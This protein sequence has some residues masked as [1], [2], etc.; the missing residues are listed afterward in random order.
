MTLFSEKYPKSARA[1]DVSLSAYTAWELEC[2]FHNW[3]TPDVRLYGMADALLLWAASWYNPSDLFANARF[4]PVFYK[5]RQEYA[6][7]ARR[8]V[9]DQR[10]KRATFQGFLDFR[11]TADQLEEMDE[12][13]PTPAQI[14]ELV[15]K[16]MNDG[17]RL[18]LSYS[19]KTKT[20]SCT[21]MDDNPARKSG[22]WGL[23]SA[24]GDAAHALKAACYKHFLVLQGTWATLLDTPI[25]RGQRG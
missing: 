19:A 16:L 6:I 2:A 4:F 10:E 1:F 22:G 7:M 5:L 14:W 24:D 3:L 20:A 13:L 25:V 21:L 9:E 8:K 18:T 11:L 12:W 23:S 15:D 17:Y